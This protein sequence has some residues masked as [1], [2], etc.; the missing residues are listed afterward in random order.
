MKQQDKEKKSEEYDESYCI[1]CNRRVT[2]RKNGKDANGH[3]K[4][5]KVEEGKGGNTT[6]YENFYFK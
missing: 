2:W 5:K 6:I 4:P 1:I 3:P